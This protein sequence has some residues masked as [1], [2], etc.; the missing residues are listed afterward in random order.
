MSEIV[1]TL[2]FDK[3]I[4]C[5]SSKT[6]KTSGCQKLGGSFQIENFEIPDRVHGLTQRTHMLKNA[7]FPSNVVFRLTILNRTMIFLSR[8]N[9]NKSKNFFVLSWLWCGSKLNLVV[10]GSRNKLI[11]GLVGN[12]MIFPVYWNKTPPNYGQNDLFI[13]PIKASPS[14]LATILSLF[15]FESVEEKQIR[16]K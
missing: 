8:L 10:G 11:K 1:K 5:K 2:V 16:K 6:M 12:G 13:N 3:Y 14:S 4:A 7:L 9:Q 15:R